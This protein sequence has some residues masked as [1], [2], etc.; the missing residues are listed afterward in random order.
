M[1]YLGF[2]ATLSSTFQKILTKPYQKCH[3]S[4]TVGISIVQSPWPTAP[5]AGTT[6]HITM[7]VWSSRQ[8]GYLESSRLIHT[9]TV[10]FGWKVIHVISDCVPGWSKRWSLAA[11]VGLGGGGWRVE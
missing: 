6:R 2:D 5:C 4:N 9:H 10:S 7:V 8:R 3:L 11:E 1:D